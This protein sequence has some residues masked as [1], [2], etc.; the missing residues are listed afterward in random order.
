MHY[1]SQP[2]SSCYVL[3]LL[4][5]KCHSF[6]LGLIKSHYQSVKSSRS[7]S[8]FRT[9]LRQPE[10]DEVFF[11]DEPVAAREVVAKT[12]KTKGEVRISAQCSCVKSFLVQRKFPPSLNPIQLNYSILVRVISAKLLS[13]S[14][15][16]GQGIT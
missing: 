5:S 16:I 6:P 12:P 7:R 1:V 10:F 11:E 13:L 2:T 14:A 3:S 4:A 8:R 15:A 9:D